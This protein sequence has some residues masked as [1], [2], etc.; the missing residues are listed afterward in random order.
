MITVINAGGSGTRLWPLST[1]KNPKYLLNLAG[2][3]S[4]LQSAYRRAQQLS[5]TIYVITSADSLEQV[6]AQLPELPAEAIVTEPDRR[7]TA[8]CFT[9]AL[10]HLSQRHDNDEPVAF[11]HA[12]HFIRDIDGFTHSF[13]TAAAVSKEQDKIVLIGVEPTYSAT[14]FGYIQKGGELSNEPLVYNVTSFK[15]K[16]DHDTAN[17]YLQSGHYLWNAG[18]FIG[19]VNT[20]LQVMTQDAPQLKAN[21]DTLVAAQDP[22]AYQQAFLAFEKISIDYALIEKTKDLLLVPA[23]FDWIDIGSFADAHGIA[24]TDEQGNYCKGLV[25]LETVTNSYIRNEDSRPLGVIGLDNVAVVSTPEGV[26]V[27]RKDM[28]QSVKKI[29]NKF[30]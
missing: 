14:G 4:L 9:V 29:A 30:Q 10:A 2:D 26:L 20:F 6:R 13:K 19:S 5:E 27:M 1:N 23:G 25:E 3:E 21:F 24:E 22:Q 17:V 18:Y 11:L 8:G 7:D 12:D 15:E 28:S 16:P